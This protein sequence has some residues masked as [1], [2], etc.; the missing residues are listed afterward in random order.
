[1]ATAAKNTA[2]KK[3]AARQGR[4]NGDEGDNEHAKNLTATGA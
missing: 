4:G 3:E 1:M 2:V